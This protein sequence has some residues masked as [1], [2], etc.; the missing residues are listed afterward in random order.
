[1]AEQP[2]L[3]LTQGKAW[4]AE[5]VARERM[6]QFENASAAIERAAEIYVECGFELGIP[7]LLPHRRRLRDLLDTDA[8]GST[9]TPPRPAP[10]GCRPGR[11]HRGTSVSG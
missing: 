10:P 9:M 8:T 4:H 5:G 6:G 2:G 1:V 7:Q 11:C 3:L